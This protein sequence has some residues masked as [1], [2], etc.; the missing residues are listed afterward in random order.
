M[1]GRLKG[2]FKK[3]GK[4]DGFWLLRKRTEKGGWKK[5]MRLDEY[6]SPEDVYKDLSAGVY[7]LDFYLN[8]SSKPKTEWTIEVAGT[9]EEAVEKGMVSNKVDTKTIGSRSPFD[10]LMSFVDEL[11]RISEDADK[12][13]AFLNRLSGRM[14]LEDALNTMS[15]YR[16][17]FDKIASVMGYVRSDGRVRSEESELPI[18]GKIPAWAVYAPRA[19]DNVLDIVEKRLKKM[20]LVEEE[21]G[22]DVINK[23]LPEF[24]ELGK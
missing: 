2:L 14:S 4:A 24:P 3:S 21:D 12:L 17:Q 20:G 9:E 11:S 8:G 10:S 6:I 23:S 7:R 15:R 22:S 1:L 18:E 5:V 16:E 19:V 13:A